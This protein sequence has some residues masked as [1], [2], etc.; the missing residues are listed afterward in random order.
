VEQLD[1]ERDPYVQKLRERFVHA[2]RVL[3]TAREP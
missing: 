2:R 1:D 3:G